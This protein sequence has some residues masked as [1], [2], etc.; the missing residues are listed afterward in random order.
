MVKGEIREMKNI[1]F[2]LT[3]GSFYIHVSLIDFKIE[4]N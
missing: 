3:V 1:G 4:E 2:F